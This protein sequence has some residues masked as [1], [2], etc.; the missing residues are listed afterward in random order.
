MF[1]II[2]PVDKRD[3]IIKNVKSYNYNWLIKPFY[4]KR[5]W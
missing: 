3:I 2:N 1:I 4:N 5:R